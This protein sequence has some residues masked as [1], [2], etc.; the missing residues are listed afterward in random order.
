MDNYSS[1]EKE[2]LILLRDQDVC[3]IK[4][5]GNAIQKAFF[6]E[7]ET[8]LL[9][10][11][12]NR[13]ASLFFPIRKPDSHEDRKVFAQ[14]VSLLNFIENIEKSG[15]I[16]IQPSAAE[17]ELFFYENFKHSFLHGIQ[18]NGIIKEA[19]TQQE[20]IVY[21]VDKTNS[22]EVLETQIPKIKSD[23]LYV[24][25]TGTRIMQST[26]V[27]SLYDRI[28][29]LLC[30]RAF[31]TSVLSRFI[32]N[33][34]CFDEEKRSMKSL[35]YAQGSFFIAMLALFVSMPCISVW[36]SNRH[37]Y[38]TIDSVQYNTL[39][40]KLDAIEMK[41][42]ATDV[43]LQKQADYNLNCNPK[44]QANKVESSIRQ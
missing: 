17:C 6:R 1:I 30:G 37:A 29:R 10:D 40:K 21:D 16:Y 25:K 36:Y 34:Y 8:A 42:K 26:D 9:V 43:M 20:F 22:I 7:R 12:S 39:I 33:G 31:P 15:L 27:S 41:S 35:R 44:R 18:K 38:S 19:I 14:L 23:I 32:D 4:L 28:Y 24:E 3:D 13:K 11:C 5:L 2:V